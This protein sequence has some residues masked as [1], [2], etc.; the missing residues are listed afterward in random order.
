MGSSSEWKA[1]AERTQNALNAKIPQEW[2][3]P[4]HLL[5]T[6]EKDVTWVPASSGI[7]SE[8]ELAITL[9]DATEIIQKVHAGTWSAEEVCLAF[10]K[11]AAVAQQLVRIL[12]HSSPREIDELTATGELPDGDLLR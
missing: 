5:E 11:R 1:I 4:R 12:D 3:L 8:K 7:L 9:C 6:T 2:R 10:C